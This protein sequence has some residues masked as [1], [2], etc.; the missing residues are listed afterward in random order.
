MLPSKMKEDEHP[1]DVCY[2]RQELE[3]QTWQNLGK[4]L[5][6]DPD[7]S[8]M[9]THTGAS[10][11]VPVEDSV[12]DLYVTGRDTK[13]RSHIGRVRTDL[14][15]PGT[16]LEVAQDP[17]L[18][19][20]SPG[21]F[22]ENGVS[23]PWIVRN[24]SELRMYYVGWM[25]T[26]LTPFQVHV[27]LGIGKSKDRFERYSKAP[28]LE[29]TDEDY[30]GM[31]SV[32]VLKDNATW[33]M[34][35]TSFTAWENTG[36][37]RHRYLIKYAESGDGINWRR[38]DRICIPFQD[39]EEYAIC[40]PSVLK[41]DGTYHMWYCYKGRHYKIGYAVSTDGIHWERRDGRFD[42]SLSGAGWDS[43]SQ[44][45]PH[46]FGFEDHLYLIYCGNEYGRQGLGL[47]RTTTE[48]L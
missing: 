1:V 48:C 2:G 31:G 39:D 17:V 18:P 24:R 23:Y 28:I 21:A 5:S 36:R 16:I 14:K 15:R 19:L 11:A 40:R 20:G 41:V 47:A 38:H 25:P 4:I 3:R 37:L 7:S 27:G 30:L 44:A 6:P 32:C 34:W 43:E 26:V 22:D 35:Y 29:R 46:V 8:W 10:F 9:A 33:R 45:Y 13:N 42:L 12:F